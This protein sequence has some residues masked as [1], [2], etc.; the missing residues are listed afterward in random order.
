MEEIWKTIVKNGENTQYQISN[1]GRV[2][3]LNMAK[4]K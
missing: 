4:R 2:K 1:I 3:S